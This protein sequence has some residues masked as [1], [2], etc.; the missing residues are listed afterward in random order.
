MGTL[1]VA[2]AEMLDAKT[3]SRLA[4]HY[5][6]DATGWRVETRSRIR[7]HIDPAKPEE[8]LAGLGFNLNTYSP[9]VGLAIFGLTVLGAGYGLGRLVAW[10]TKLGG[11][12]A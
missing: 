1:K 3:K 7:V 5:S 2:E 8:P 4:R 11:R 12:T 6:T 9:A 10:F